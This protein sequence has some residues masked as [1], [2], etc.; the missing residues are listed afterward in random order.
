V[1]VGS[2]GVLCIRRGSNSSAENA[3]SQLFAMAM[4]RSCYLISKDS[5]GARPPTESLGFPSGRPTASI[6]TLFPSRAQ[7]IPQSASNHFTVAVLP[8]CLVGNSNGR[9]PASNSSRQLF[10]ND[11]RLRETNEHPKTS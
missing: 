11:W 1:N 7:P 4:K 8:E 5:S 3:A 10:F 6:F 9:V 2:F